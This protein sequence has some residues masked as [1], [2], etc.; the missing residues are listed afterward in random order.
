MNQSIVIIL[1]LIAI[2]ILMSLDKRRISKTRL[3]R[4]GTVLSSVLC[5]VTL[6]IWLVSLMCFN[7][8]LSFPAGQKCYCEIGFFVGTVGIGVTRYDN[9]P[10]IV[11]HDPQND[12]RRS[13]IGLDYSPPKGIQLFSQWVGL[14]EGYPR[15]FNCSIVEQDYS[16]NDY[17]FKYIEIPYLLIAWIFAL[18]LAVR[19]IRRKLTPPRQKSV[20][21]WSIGILAGFCLLVVLFYA[22]ENWRGRR[23]WENFRRE[24]EAKGER[25]DWRS[26]VP[27]PVPEDQNFALTPVVY[28]SYGQ[29]L[30]RAGQAI[31]QEK[32]NSNSVNRLNMDVYFYYLQ[33]ESLTNQPDIFYAAY[34]KLEQTNTFGSWAKGTRLNLISFQQFYRALAGFTGDIKVLPQ[35]QAPA[36]DVLLTLGTF[37]STIEEL[38]AAARRPF[39]RF[40]LEYDEDCWGNIRLPHLSVLK[41]CLQVLHLRAG[42]E[43]QNGQNEKALDDVKLSLR[44]VDSIR[45]EPFVISHL[46]RAELLQI[47]LNPIYQGL[48]EH[49]WTDAQL[50]ALG[51]DLQKIDFLAD[52]RT[53]MR[54]ER[55][56]DVATVNWLQRSRKNYSK[57]GA[58]SSES[59]TLRWIMA[60]WGPSGWLEQNKIRICGYFTNLDAV[61]DFKIRTVQPEA[62]RQPVKVLEAEKRRLTP[63]NFLEEPLLPYL[64]A[65]ITKFAYTQTAA[66]L[67]R[68]ACA[69]ER[70]RLAHGG[71]P[72]TLNALV[73]HFIAQV[74]HDVIGGQPLKYRRTDDG[75]F[76][77]YSI[78]WNE[79]DDG[80]V[81]AFKK[82]STSI[83]IG[84]GDW[85][86]K[87]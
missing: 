50:L 78:G 10:V 33:T 49:C 63:F 32:W 62:A 24:W 1:L 28:S 19:G 9:T 26:V 14:S 4:N 31:P 20:F 58:V 34:R 61:V 7:W 84:N 11:R 86:W 48:S 64:T 46:V 54:G 66:D 59:G 65:V 68:T 27:P 23:A 16:F 38:R 12:P 29:E 82:D 43:L 30:T 47:A 69:L 15:L 40:P 44:L 37:D 60:T 80:G 75:K 72:E 55:A 81:V 13:N 35:A 51:A 8:K 39:S 87:Y 6:I 22:E 57:F 17:R 18:P 74:P 21:H 56:G 2:F 42:A 3:L 76:I 52:C 79:K 71:Y 5:G 45:N 25:F 41:R 70:Y 53:A 73:P 77:L 85:V 83:D 36:T 67:A